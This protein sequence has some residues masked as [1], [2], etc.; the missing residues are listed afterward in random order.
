MAEKHT[1]GGR[2]GWT[3]SAQEFETNFGN[4]SAIVNTILRARDSAQT[5]LVGG[6]AGMKKTVYNKQHGARMN[7]GETDTIVQAGEESMKA[8][9]VRE[10]SQS[11]PFS[12]QYHFT[13]ENATQLL[14]LSTR[15]A[16]VCGH[17][18]QLRAL[19][20]SAPIVV[21]SFEL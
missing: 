7:A 6:V 17:K 18:A 1:L 19:S 11:S 8:G 9:I 21:A 3:A 13:H 14:D 5:A 12:T 4:T 2:G 20:T 10:L 16:A 15:A